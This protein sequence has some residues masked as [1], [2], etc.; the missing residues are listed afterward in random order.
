MENIV[1]KPHT[2]CWG[3]RLVS[4]F[5]LAKPICSGCPAHKE[6]SAICEDKI[7]IRQKEDVDVEPNEPSSLLRR[8][9]GPLSDMI[10]PVKS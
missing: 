4:L 1:N 2:K 3:R 7:R 6:K 10:G 8:Y 9:M 5:P